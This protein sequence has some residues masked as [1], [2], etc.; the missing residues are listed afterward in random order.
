MIFLITDPPSEL[1][2]DANHLLIT[3]YIVDKRFEEAQQISTDMRQSSPTSIL[4]LVDAAR[5]SKAIG[6][7]NEALSLLKEAY[8]YAKK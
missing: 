4:N 7:N 3:I 5:I 6:E 2:E 1:R 8:S